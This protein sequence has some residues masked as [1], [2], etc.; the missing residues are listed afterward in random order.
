MRRKKHAS[1]WP[2]LQGALC[3]PQLPLHQHHPPHAAIFQNGKKGKR[4]KKASKKEGNHVLF[5][6]GRKRKIN[7]LKKVLSFCGLRSCANL[8][9]LSGNIY[10]PSPQ[11]P[12]ISPFQIYKTQDVTFLPLMPRLT[13][14]LLQLL[15]RNAAAAVDRMAV[16]MIDQVEKG[17]AIESTA[18]AEHV[19]HA[20]ATCVSYI[21]CLM[22]ACLRP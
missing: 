2:E 1:T 10:P 19:L 22:P 13:G 17:V 11:N 14:S 7:R 21:Y 20:C 6:G 15:G 9:H 16:G 4:N 8:A 3:A 5:W 18:C 12:P